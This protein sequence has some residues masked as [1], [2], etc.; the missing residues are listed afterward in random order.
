MKFDDLVEYK[1]KHGDLNIP[2][3]YEPNPALHKWIKRQRK[4]HREG[5]M[6]DDKTEK[7]KGIGFNFGGPKQQKKPWE[8]Q[9]EAMAGKSIELSDLTVIILDPVSTVSHFQYCLCP[10]QSSKLRMAILIYR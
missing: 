3:D 1:E 10:N 9:F 7:L 2:V 5:Q 6:K 8:E 4:Y